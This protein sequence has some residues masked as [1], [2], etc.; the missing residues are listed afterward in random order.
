MPR[1]TLA[2][3]HGERGRVQSRR[4]CGTVHTGQNVAHRLFVISQLTRLTRRHTLRVCLRVLI[5]LRTQTLVRRRRAR[6]CGLG[7]GRALRTI[8]IAHVVLV[9]ISHTRF[10]EIVGIPKVPLLTRARRKTIQSTR[11]L[12]QGRVTLI[13]R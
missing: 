4:I 5:P 13:A 6:A 1:H 3:R 2:I 7:I 10:T 11:R 12:M 9:L 8:I